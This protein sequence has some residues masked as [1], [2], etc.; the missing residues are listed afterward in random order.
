MNQKSQKAVHSLNEQFPDDC[1]ICLESMIEVSLRQVFTPCRHRFHHECLRRSL[2]ADRQIECPYCRQNLS[3]NW[4]YNNQLIIQITREHYWDLV[5][6]QFGRPF[7]YGPLIPTQQRIQDNAFHRR[8]GLPR[9]W[10]GEWIEDKLSECRMRFNIPPD[11]VLSYDDLQLIEERGR[12]GIIPEWT[13]PYEF[14][15]FVE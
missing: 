10:D 9:L 8:C 5:D 2:A 1:P 14:E 11:F 4:L 15:I 3:D 13:M 6:D 7:G 12:H